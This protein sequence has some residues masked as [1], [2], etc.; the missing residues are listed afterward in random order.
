M[1]SEW[2]SPLNRCMKLWADTRNKL[3]HIP[4][5][6]LPCFSYNI[7]IHL[8]TFPLFERIFSFYNSRA[9]IDYSARMA[10]FTIK[11]HGMLGPPHRDEDEWYELGC[12]K[13][14]FWKWKMEC[15]ERRWSVCASW[16]VATERSADRKRMWKACGFWACLRGIRY[17]GYGYITF[18]LLLYIEA[19]Y[20]QMGIIHGENGR[21][22]EK[23]C[24][25][26]LY[27]VVGIRCSLG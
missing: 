11:L 16:A 8:Q 13:W 9:R 21:K 20:R 18:T 14:V 26:F 19:S 25:P 27:I 2:P 24:V 23:N 15:A 6:W 17:T 1:Q 5:E 22:A 3:P 4:F 10:I 7:F 12:R